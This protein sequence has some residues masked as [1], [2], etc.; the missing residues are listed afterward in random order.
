IQTN[1]RA[2]SV[3]SQPDG[4]V[5]V[6]TNHGTQTFDRVVLTTPS[7]IIAQLCPQLGADERRRHEA[8]QYLGI[9]CAS[10]LLRKPLASYYVTNITDAGLPYTAVIEMTTLV[11]PAELGGASL[12]YL[13]RYAAGDDEVWRLTDEEIQERF[14]AGLER[15]YPDFH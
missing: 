7:S 5:E 4:T 6:E 14:L 2:T 9:V 3:L 15:M 8:I 11:D 12:V 1:C 13:P 10:V